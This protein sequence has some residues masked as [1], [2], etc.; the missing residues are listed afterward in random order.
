MDKGKIGIINEIF[1]KISKLKG[2]YNVIIIDSMVSFTDAISNIESELQLFQ[3]L[4]EEGAALELP[5]EK[6]KRLKNETRQ[7]LNSKAG[8]YHNKKY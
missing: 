8:K 1:D 7:F 4:V 2:N 6:I 5:N 3:E